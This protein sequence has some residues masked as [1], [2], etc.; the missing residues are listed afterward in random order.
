MTAKEYIIND[1]SEEWLK[2]E[3]QAGDVIDALQQFAALKIAEATKEMYP[4]EFVVW[5]A[6]A[7]QEQDLWEGTGTVKWIYFTGTIN[8]KFNSTDELFEYWKQN[9]QGK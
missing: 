7:A 1:W 4:K 6:I 2:H 9:I 3:W 8:M 5:M